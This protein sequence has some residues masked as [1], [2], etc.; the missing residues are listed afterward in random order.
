MKR[1]IITGAGSFIG[2]A[3][4]KQLESRGYLVSRLRHS[5]GRGFSSSTSESLPDKADIWLHFAWA[6]P[7]S[8][9]RND[10]SIQKYNLAMSLEALKTAASKECQK[11]IFSGSQAEYGHAQ[12]G[13]LKQ[14]NGPTAPLSEYARAKHKFGQNAPE[15][16]REIGSQ[17]QYIHLRI[18]SAFGPGDHEG[19][20]INTLISN[21][22]LG[23]RV[24]L[25]SCRQLWNYIFIDD[26]ARAISLL[27]ERGGSGIYNVGSSDVRPLREYVFEAAKVIAGFDVSELLHFDTRK[28]NAEGDADLSPDVSKIEKLGF[29]AEVSFT[30][31]IK[32]TE[33]AIR[34]LL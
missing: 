12:D 23:K 6:G 11:F 33:N 27:C 25:G 29:K 22:S 21:L 8:D 30:E 7:G 10:A 19:S 31:G 28:D 3:S 5:A 9:G 26:L 20:L 18:F 15:V 4:A 1:A 16:L 14:E 17:M 24:Q 32:M 13:H 2:S 34:K